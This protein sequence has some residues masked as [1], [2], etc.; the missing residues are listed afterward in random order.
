MKSIARLI[1]LSLCLVVA[2]TAAEVPVSVGTVSGRN[3]VVVAGHPQA[4][5]AGLEVLRAGGNAIDAAVATSLALGVA[6]PY[7]SG[8]GGKLILLFFE[9]K[10]GRIHVVDGLDAAG[11]GFTV[12]QFRTRPEEDRRFGGGALASRSALGLDALVGDGFTRGAAR[13]GWV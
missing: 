2:L 10:S 11:T 6:E 4:A 3:G 13:P 8:L 1:S 12:E 9:A 5:A 7:G